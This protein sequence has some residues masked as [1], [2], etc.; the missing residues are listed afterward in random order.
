[1]LVPRLENN[2]PENIKLAALEFKDIVERQYYGSKVSLRF[3]A[4]TQVEARV[5][6]NRSEKCY[7]V[8]FGIQR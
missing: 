7:I 4:D 3:V 6:P 1:M 2:D 8:V 5:Y